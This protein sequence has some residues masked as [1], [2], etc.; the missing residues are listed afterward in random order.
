MYIYIYVH[1][2]EMKFIKVDCKNNKSQ[3]SILIFEIN[4]YL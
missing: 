3:I 2:V 4:P 1:L